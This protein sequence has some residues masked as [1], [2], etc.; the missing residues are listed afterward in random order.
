MYQLAEQAKILMAIPIGNNASPI[1]SQYI[2]LIGLNGNLYILVNLLQ[3]SAT[4]CVFTFEVGTAAAPHT[5]SPITS[6]SIHIWYNP[7][8]ASTDVLIPQPTSFNFTTD[9]SIAHKQILFMLRTD[10][11]RDGS[12]TFVMKVAA[13][14]SNNNLTASFILAN[15][16]NEMNTLAVVII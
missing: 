3:A 16:R 7:T 5:T 6:N 14:S 12:S 9:A 13:S 2:S 10:S 8:A 1:V 11:V 15:L 4:P